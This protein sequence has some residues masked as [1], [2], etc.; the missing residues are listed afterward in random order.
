MQEME[1]DSQAFDQIEREFQQVLSEL[2]TDQSL[3]RFRQEFDRLHRSLKISHENQRRLISKCREYNADIAQNASKIQTVLKMT[4]DDA[5]TI[6]HLRT[7][8][9]KMYRILELAQDREE[10]SK[11]KMENLNNEIKQLHNLIEQ[12]NSM[13]S[14]QKVTV[15]E[16]LEKKEKFLKE[17]DTLTS[18][19]TAARSDLTMINDKVKTLEMQRDKA[20]SEQKILL[21]QKADFEGKLAEEESSKKETQKELETIKQQFDEQKTLYQAIV[22]EKKRLKTDIEKYRIIY[23]NKS[24][25]LEQDRLETKKTEKEIMDQQGRLDQQYKLNEILVN[26]QQEAQQQIDQL[27]EDLKQVE[28]EIRQ[29]QIKNNQLEKQIEI[30]KEVKSEAEQMK[31]ITIQGVN[32]IQDEINGEKKLAFEDR[33]TIENLRRAR[34]IL[35]KEIDRS[36]NNNKKLADDLIAKQKYFNEKKNEL[37]GLS[38]KMEYLNKQIS[39]LDKE[40]EN[41]ALQF[42]QAQI[43]YFHSLDEIKLKDSLISEFQKKNIETEAK[44]K[45]QQNLYES[46]RSDRNLYSKNYTE[47]QQEIE[48]S[49]RR[50]KIVNHS[51]SQLKEEIDA[52]G[53]QL[54][55]EHNE[56]KKKDKTIEEQAKTL[57][58]YKSDIVEKENKIKSFLTQISQLHFIIK[59][60]EQAQQKL[61]EQFDQVVAE[62]DI[63]STQ[64]IRRT[65]ETELLYEKI[66]IN[67]STLQKGELQYQEKLGDIEALKTKIADYKREIKKFKQEANTIRDLQS[68]T[69]NLTK[70]LIEER[71]KAKALAEELEN[72]M[73][74]HRWRKLEATDSENYELMTK[75]QSLQKRLIQKTEEVVYKEKLVNEKEKDLKNLKDEMKRKPGLEEERMIPIYEENLRQKDQQMTAMQQELNMYQ[76]HINEYKLEINRINSELQ[77]TKKRYFDQKKREQQQKDLKTQEEA[78]IIQTILPEKKFVGGGFALQK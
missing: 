17:K 9:E 66:Q 4:S 47:K 68:D 75:I 69:H 58:K 55:N 61:K 20:S 78:Q 71:L 32:K 48:E 11:T 65:A 41:Y 27:Q 50:Y 51:I 63:L 64:Y 2:A 59:E 36:D 26:K 52:K 60:G 33:Q 25:E 37:Q 76:S 8:L 34:N 23:S 22:D 39:I 44:L 29:G 13:T 21:Q 19:V 30:L 5:N 18:L 72:P 28:E 56:H 49:R 24:K 12:S 38:K 53:R 40:K 42:S 16:L 43:K 10:K 1:V 46:V 74:V 54:T 31:E 57:E 67:Q 3:D 62:R 14:G 7:E 6:Q 35:Q 77:I 73:N 45:Q 70:E 15:Q